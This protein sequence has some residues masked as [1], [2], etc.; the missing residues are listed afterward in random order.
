M[1]KENFLG[2]A[3]RMVDDTYKRLTWLF[4][5]LLSSYVPSD[6]SQKTY[7]KAVGDL[8]DAMNKLDVL[9]YDLM[10]LGYDI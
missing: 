5:G 7:I 4:S 8:N 9:K 1:D 3:I 2:E 10:K 6:I